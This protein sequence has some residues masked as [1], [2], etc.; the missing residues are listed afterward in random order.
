M[1]QF[2]QYQNPLAIAM[3]SGFERARVSVKV[4]SENYR[5]VIASVAKAVRNGVPLFGPDESPMCASVR[6]RPARSA[7]RFREREVG[8]AVRAAKAAGAER[9]EIDP[10]TG[11][12]SVHLNTAGDAADNE[13]EDWFSKQR[14]HADQR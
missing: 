6:Q 9:V 4:T 2:P 1:T 11:K 10:T 5:D 7:T 12:I 13:V 8:R 14:R 3:P